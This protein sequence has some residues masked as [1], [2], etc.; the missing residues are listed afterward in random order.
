MLR[1]LVGPIVVVT[2]IAACGSTTGPGTGQSFSGGNG[3]A[4]GSKSGAAGVG[5]SG[6]GGT[7]GSGGTLNL[8]G[9]SSG[10]SSGS[11]LADA[12]AG[13][14][15]Q[16]ET[17][18]T[19]QDVTTTETKPIAVYFMQDQSGSMV[20]TKWTTAVNAITS[21]V[22]DP[23]SANLDV[24]I[25]FFPDLFVSCN[26]QTYA[27]P[28][29]PLG[30]LPAY[31][32][33]IINTV[34]GQV[35][36]GFGTPIEAALAGAEMFCENFKTLTTRNPPDEDCVVIFITDGNA[37]SCSTDPNVIS[38]YAADAWK[39]S[40]VHTYAIGMDGADFTLLDQIATSGNT[41]CGATPSCNATSGS[42]GLS[43]ALA[44]I[45]DT[46]TTTV[47]QTK[48]I[49]TP[50][51]C[52]WGIPPPPTGQ[53]LDPTQVNVD[54]LANGQKTRLGQVP[55]AADCTKYTNGWYY[56]D[57]ANPTKIIACADTCTAVTAPG[58]AGV[59]ISLGCATERAVPR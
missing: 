22:N 5:G 42:A 39:N 27:T 56:D 54:L 18:T 31:A 29:V 50:L 58:V 37:T 12:C 4:S 55:S 43:A 44:S 23:S 59:S 11:N 3:G 47:T 33:T 25:Q 20:G 53:T 28:M 32:P 15:I 36:L 45:R 19:T 26:A 49:T 17:L 7:V 21:F 9:T 14:D 8:G 6:A 13:V 30:R 38:K 52:E 34:N 40:Q 2:L 10:G 24:T 51:T 35:P 1:R 41:N 46:I 48:T 16:P 57:P